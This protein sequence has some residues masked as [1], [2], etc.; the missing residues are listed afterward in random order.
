MP[1]RRRGETAVGATPGSAPDRGEPVGAARRIVARERRRCVD[2]R[3]AFAAL[4]DAVADLETA[5]VRSDPVSVPAGPGVGTGGAAGPT[6]GGVRAA[7]ERTVMSVPHYEAE[8]GESYRE[9][10]AVEFGPDLAA[11]LT[12]PVTL[13]PRLR[14]AAVTAAGLAREE[15]AAFVERLD[16]ERASL[17]RVA[18][19]IAAVRADLAARDDRPLGD[20]SFDDLRGLRAAV[21]DL[22][23]RIDDLAAARQRR[24]ARYRGEFDL[25]DSSL[26]AY[27][28]AELET[29]HPALAALAS[30]GGTLATARRRVE[31]ALAGTA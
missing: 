4:A 14:E 25:V 29:D 11:A 26:P 8:Y 19:G 5:G 6:T 24:L 20:R 22:R 10:L 31:R 21:V 23:G 15:R 28:Y 17:D 7:Y 27:L 30:V 2:E 1:E 9:S 18:D 16:A 3:E 13:T 12:G